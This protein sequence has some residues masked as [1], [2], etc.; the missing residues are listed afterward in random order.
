[1]KVKVFALI[2][3]LLMLTACGEEAD[4][5]MHLQVNVPAVVETEATS[6]EQPSEPVSEVESEVSQAPEKG[7]LKPQEETVEVPVEVPESAT[8]EEPVVEASEPPVEEP[9][10]PV[11][12][13]DPEDKLSGEIIANDGFCG[14]AYLGYTAK[15]YQEIEDFLWEKGY[16]ERY[17]VLQLLEEEFFVELPGMEL[18]VAF[19]PNPNAILRVYEYTFDEEGN[20]FP[21]ELQYM[22]QGSVPVL[23]RGNVSDIVPNLY[24]ELENEEFIFGYPLGLS[25]EDGELSHC[26]HSPGIYD[27]SEYDNLLID[28]EYRLG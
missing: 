25:M 1:M 28:P 6:P 8:V 14:V 21:G 12:V 27:F 17:P 18:Y 7:G 2:L 19:T 10:E 16:M 20:V 11:I 3:A 9:Q 26:D 13:E 22:I 5:S 23:L 4:S 24:L 15:S